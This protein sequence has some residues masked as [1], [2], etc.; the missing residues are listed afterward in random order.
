M[1]HL[2]TRHKV[3][4]GGRIVTAYAIH[5][6]RKTA[7]GF[8]VF[9]FNTTGTLYRVLPC[10]LLITLSNSRLLLVIFP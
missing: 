8:P 4:E 6:R 7:P 5:K 10:L 1:E 2:P 9:L 3:W